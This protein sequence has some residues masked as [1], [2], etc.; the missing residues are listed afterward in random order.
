VFKEFSGKRDLLEGVRKGFLEGKKEVLVGGSLRHPSGTSRAVLTIET[1]ATA[2]SQRE[3][4]GGNYHLGGGSTRG[5]LVFFFRRKQ[6]EVSLKNGG[7]DGSF[8]GSRKR[9]DCAS[10]RPLENSSDRSV[11]IEK[12]NPPG[13]GKKKSPQKRIPRTS[14][15]RTTSGRKPRRASKERRT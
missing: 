14:I 4:H 2:T 1:N 3:D 8:L 5:S 12:R 10:Y 15:S 7:G 11:S 13:G 6:G 9:R